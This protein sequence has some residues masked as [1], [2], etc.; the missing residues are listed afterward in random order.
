MSNHPPEENRPPIDHST[1][2]G[3]LE[4]DREL[5]RE[6]HAVFLEEA[7]RQFRQLQAALANEDRERSARHA[8]TLKGMAGQIGAFLLEKAC[9][10]L[11]ATLL[12][13]TGDPD[14]ESIRQ[15]A[16]LLEQVL[17]ELTSSENA[18]L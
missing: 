10:H 14:P 9:R 15:L 3:H 13:E 16:R 8:H 5:L 12:N 7:P 2:L 4:G 11:E 1:A 6:I 17:A 18:P